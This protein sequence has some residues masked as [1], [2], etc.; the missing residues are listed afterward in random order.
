[1]HTDTQFNRSKSMAPGTVAEAVGMNVES[2]SPTPLTSFSDGTGSVLDLADARSWQHLI[3]TRVPLEFE[4]GF[5]AEDHEQPDVRTAAQHMDNIRSV[6]RP[7]VTDMAKVFNVSR[8]AI[9]KWINAESAPEPA[10]LERIKALSR[11]A[12]AFS[13]AGIKHGRA[14]ALLKMKAFNGRSL[15]DL[16]ASDQ[17]Q[18]EQI[19]L[20]IA[21]AKAMEKA[22][23]RSG[24]AQSKTTPSSDWQ[25]SISIPGTAGD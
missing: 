8:Q 5:S 17:I 2:A 13:E 20:L 6:L 23:D 19:Q 14:V 12:D 16:A 15:L 4:F 9:Y 25:S 18:P 21:E 24:L 10:S 1:M 22:Y 11:V 7:A 3:K